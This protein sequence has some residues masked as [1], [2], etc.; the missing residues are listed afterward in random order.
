[1]IKSDNSVIYIE[2]RPVPSAET[3][4]VDLLSA[5][6]DPGS[7]ICRDTLP[8][9]GLL[10]FTRALGHSDNSVRMALSRLVAEDLVKRDG[11]GCYNYGSA[12]HRRHLE[13]VG[14]HQSAMRVDTRWDGSWLGLFIKGKPSKSD[15]RAARLAGFRQY[16]DSLMVRP[17]NLSRDLISLKDCVPEGFANG[18]YWQT[19]LSDLNNEQQRHFSA[20][21]D[22]E[23][24]VQGYKTL[25][26][27]KLPTKKVN[28]L[29]ALRDIVTTTYLVGR[30]AVVTVVSDPLLP[31]EM[32]DVNLRAK[33]IKRAKHYY[34]QSSKYWATLI[35]GQFDVR[36]DG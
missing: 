3:S 5:L 8:L 33:A 15:Q 19:R 34:D 28:N 7:P 1:M 12:G 20:L 9:A 24:I 13:M 23:N 36:I 27:L 17:G 6:A 11:R 29:Q 4:V 35:D 10:R 22:T 30:E 2:S 14:W 25:I 21:Y 26:K 31:K 18:Q 16:D 32:I